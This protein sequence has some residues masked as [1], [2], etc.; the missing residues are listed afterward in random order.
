MNRKPFTTCA[1]L[2]VLLLAGCNLAPAYHP[3]TTVAIPASFK[4]AP[5]WAPARPSDDV[6]RGAWW[7]LF[8]DPV[9]DGLERKVEVTNQNVA[10]SRAAYQAARAIVAVQRSNL[11]PT[12]TGSVSA[13]RTEPFSATSGTDPTTSTGSRFA[14]GI[15]ASWEPDL[16]GRL[17]NA[18]TQAGANAQAAAGDLAN[19][20]LSAQGELATDYVQLRGIDD[21]R[22]L[23][24]ATIKDY[25]RALTITT[26]KYNAGTV[27]HSDVYQAQTSL[28]NATATRQDL[29]R[30]RGLLEHAIAVLIGENPSTFSLAQT[31]VK[32]TVPTTPGILPATLLERRPDIAA[33]ERRV[34]A[35]N[36]NIGIQRAAYFP[37]ISLSANANTDGGSVKQLFSAATSLWSLGLTGLMTLLDFGA[38]HGQVMQAHAEYD[39]AVATYRQTTLTAF[40]QVE[41]NLI[42]TRVLAGVTKSR[43]TAAD[44]ANRA[45]TIANNQ[46]LAGIIDYSQVIV[47]QTTAFNARQTQIQAVI[48]QQTATIALM[49]A[50]GGK[51]E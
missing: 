12:V 32:P 13:A 45:E 34:A 44:S 30:Q 50:I 24:D 29:D 21:Q 20:T 19:A 46:Y 22:V 8:G 5:D 17:S 33:A 11:F 26:N 28:A 18:V 31:D 43:I 25:A 47:A 15:G 38:R 4:E 6:A 41:D 9:L 1:S 37:Q 10:A 36:A 2:A 49:Q 27:A 40:Q 42:A 39:Q 51:W 3:P 23:L 14:L 48:D 35:A 16:W 7:S